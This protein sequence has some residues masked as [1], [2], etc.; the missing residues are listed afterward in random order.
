[1]IFA[2]SHLLL[3]CNYVPVQVRFS[4]EKRGI[5]QGFIHEAANS[6]SCEL[7]VHKKAQKDLPFSLLL[8][9]ITERMVEKF[10]L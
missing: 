9:F 1:M 7:N 4:R 6:P 2:T 5:L 3:H 8:N 10:S